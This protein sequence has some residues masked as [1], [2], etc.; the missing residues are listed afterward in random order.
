MNMIRIVNKVSLVIKLTDNIDGSPIKNG[1]VKIRNSK[2][3]NKKDGYYVFVN[4]DFEW[5]FMEITANQYEGVS[6]SRKEFLNN[7]I[8]N[9]MI[10]G[11]NPSKLSPSYSSFL[12]IDGT[13]ENIKADEVSLIVLDKKDGY[14]LVKNSEKNSEYIYINNR[15]DFFEGKFYIVDDVEDFTGELIY[16]YD[17]S[18][19]DKGIECRL[20][21]PLDKSH[22]IG[23]KIYRSYTMRIHDN[24]FKLSIKDNIEDHVKLLIYIEGS[25]PIYI[26]VFKENQ[27]YLSIHI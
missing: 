2:A 23:T 9:E 15:Y 19:I 13:I 24:K 6:I 10:V 17:Y 18:A 11:L 8:D 5:D 7:C 25:K 21:S 20:K 4:I 27:K 26:K 12:K 22:T 3:I 14:L 16:I 1:H